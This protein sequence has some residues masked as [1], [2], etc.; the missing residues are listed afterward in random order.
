M[1]LALTI[2]LFMFSFLAHTASVERIH[3]L[4]QKTLYTC[5]ERIWP[6]LDWQSFEI[7]LVSKTQAVQISKGKLV[8]LDPI[9]A[10]LRGKFRFEKNGIT[11]NLEYFQSPQVAFEF[12]V[13][14][15]FHAVGQKQLRASPSAQQDVYPA[16]YV[17]RLER[18][19]LAQSLK[20]YLTGVDQG[21]SKPAT[22]FFRH[23]AHRE[24]L[25]ADLI[26]GSAEYV[27]ALASGISKL[28]C[29]VSESKLIDYATQR[30]TE[31][32]MPFDKSLE[33]YRIGALSFLLAR[34]HNISPLKSFTENIHPLFLV[35]N[36]N[37]V[38]PT[39]SSDPLLD[40]SA[41]MISDL[42]NRR[43]KEIIDRLAE[44]KHYVFV[45]FKHV[46]GS[47]DHRG[48]FAHEGAIYYE[49]L[50][51]NTKDELIVNGHAVQKNHCG[52][53]GF[54]VSVDAP[55]KSSI[56]ESLKTAKVYCL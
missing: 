9:K 44:S 52:T 13:H 31:N 19:E 40:H 6:Q 4:V 15:L 23:Q 37:Q 32:G 8:S 50:T 39:L 28:G 33:H 46:A 45:S 24:D 21:L 1:K 16:N 30:V 53:T 55:V 18:E 3:T 54:L 38:D 29:Q 10:G 7:N 17:P 36:K 14:E 22:W 25:S 12:M 5:G 34:K 26:E 43:N 35:V 49:D 2:S 20:S 41:E 48:S 51:V 56:T 27:E 42:A 47:F 11:L